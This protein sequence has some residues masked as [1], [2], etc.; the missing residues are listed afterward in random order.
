METVGTRSRSGYVRS[1]HWAE[2]L[3][4]VSL[5]KL[6]FCCGE[7]SIISSARRMDHMFRRPGFYL[8]KCQCSN[9][10]IGLVGD[11]TRRKVVRKP[12]RSTI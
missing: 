10:L 1:T 3:S 7:S 8:G 2:S 9:T 6:R 12:S 4:F 5:K 11:G